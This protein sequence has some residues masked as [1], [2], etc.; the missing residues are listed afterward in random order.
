MWV[1]IFKNKKQGLFGKGGDVAYL[2]VFFTC[3]RKS[4]SPFSSPVFCVSLHVVSP[5]AARNEGHGGWRWQPCWLTM[6]VLAWVNGCGCERRRRPWGALKGKAKGGDAVSD[7]ALQQGGKE[8][9]Q[10]S[11]YRP[12]H[13]RLD[14]DR[15]ESDARYDES[16]SEILK[17]QFQSINLVRH[18][19]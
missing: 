16:D 9:W 1:S 12:S 6:V 8:W 3:S 10:G 4:C 18:E 14:T 5:P 13:I 2:V 15:A 11:K 19:D 17:S 7:G